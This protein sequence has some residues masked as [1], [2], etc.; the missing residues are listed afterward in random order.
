MRRAGQLAARALAHVEPHLLP[1][2]ST[3]S[4]DERI[5]EFLASEGA[6]AA[7]VGY[8]GY[9]HSS[10]IS[11]NEVVCHGVPSVSKILASG[12]IVNID[13]TAVVDGWHGD[14]SKTFFVGGEASASANAQRL[15]RVTRESLELGVRGCRPGGHVGDIT[16]PIRK[17]LEEAG[18]AVVNHYAAHGVGLKFHQ[19][20]TIR[21]G[22]GRPGRGTPLRPG[23][24]FTI[25]PMASEGTARTRTLG[26][27]W[28]VVTADGRLSAQYEHTV[29]VNDDACEIFT[30]V[31]GVAEFI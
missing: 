6:R 19:P 24:F 20:P 10:C 25:E 2:T 15:V 26:D 29:G 31:P 23:M 1:G 28:T 30:R 12:D 21:H 5:R 9:N 16:A 14:T 8:R 7:T 18:Y 17:H 11:V 13:V 22:S 3:A 27:G 4:V